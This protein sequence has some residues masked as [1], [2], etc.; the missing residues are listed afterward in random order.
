[1]DR[2]E[3]GPAVKNRAERRKVAKETARI[4]RKVARAAKRRSC[5]GCTACCGV[6]QVEAIDKGL[7]HSC[8]HQAK[9]CAIHSERPADCRAFECFWLQ[10]FFLDE[11]RPDLTGLVSLPPAEAQGQG[12]PIV[13]YEAWPGAFL[14]AK[15]LRFLL[16]LGQVQMIKVA[17]GT[18]PDGLVTMGRVS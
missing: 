15:G 17:H 11:D 13:L 10:G 5:G 2:G 7:W 8:L 14:S 18:R 12:Q 6:F 16:R 9:G 4:N 3:E 1:M